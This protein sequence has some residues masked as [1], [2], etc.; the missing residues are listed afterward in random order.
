MLSDEF[1]TAPPQSWAGASRLVKSPRHTSSTERVCARLSFCCHCVTRSHR[2]IET[3]RH[4]RVAPTPRAN[5][6]DNL[7]RE[8]DPPLRTGS[9]SRPRLEDFV[10]SEPTPSRAWSRISRTPLESASLTQTAAPVGHV[11][12]ARGGPSVPS[13]MHRS[14]APPAGL[15]RWPTQSGSAHASCRPP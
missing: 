11:P 1:R 13:E 5:K 4:S 2:L 6:S 10:A 15:R 3:H 14:H 9:G 12:A 8:C 7:A